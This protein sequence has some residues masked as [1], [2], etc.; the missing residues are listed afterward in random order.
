MGLPLT[1]FTIALAVLAVAGVVVIAVDLLR[2]SVVHD[3][4]E[5][6]SC[7]KRCAAHHPFHRG[8]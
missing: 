4:K 1:V 6:K 5:G 2:S 8:R 3:H 7:T